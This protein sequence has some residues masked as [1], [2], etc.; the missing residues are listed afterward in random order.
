MRQSALSLALRSVPAALLMICASL[1]AALE[2]EDRRRFGPADAARS[3]RILSTT[4]TAIFAPRIESYLRTAPEIGIDYIV[5]SSTDV[6]QAATDGGDAYDL[7]ISS[8]M[9]LQTKLANDGHVQRHSSEVTREVPAWA[10]WNDMVFAFT[11]EPAAIVV[12]DA[13][14]AAEGIPRSRQDLIDV[15]RRNPERFRGKVGT[16]D[17]RES[18]L[19]YLFATQESRV[20]ET[21]WRLTEVMGG[22]GA[23]LYCC[24]SQMID[25][26][27]GGD[28]FVAYNV[29]GSYALQRQDLSGISIIL[30][31][32]FTTIM[33]R[34]AVIPQGAP[35]PELAGDFVDHVLAQA[36]GRDPLLSVD[37]WLSNSEMALSRINLG[38]GLLVYL[39]RLKRAAFEN[40][41][42]NAILQE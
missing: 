13:A 3:L 33:L 10:K 39:D 24:S 38:P 31:S 22:L 27:S 17:V 15:L 29:L 25:A 12:S 21:Y 41:W 9:D 8:A 32:D 5:A 42:T 36:F 6:M 34:T 4:D 18:G 7:V 26:V 37:R 35:E 11:Q 2:I 19:G 1:A 23:R 14:F 30:P 28:L 20:S 16:Y 40:E